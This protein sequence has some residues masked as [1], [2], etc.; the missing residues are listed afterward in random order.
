MPPFRPAHALLVLAI[1]GCARAGAATPRTPRPDFLRGACTVYE[2]MR[3]PDG[4]Y[5]D[6]HRLDGSRSRRSSIASFGPGLIALCVEDAL[7]WNPRAEQDALLTLYLLNGRGG[8]RIERSG[9]GYFSHFFDAG[10]GVRRGNFSTID[11]AIAAA[12]AVFCANHFTNAALRAEAAELWNSVAWTDA[13]VDGPGARVHRTMAASGAPEREVSRPFNEYLLVAWYAHAQRGGAASNFF[14]FYPP[15]DRC[16]H[17]A[18][19]G[20]PTDQPARSLSTFTILFPYYLA[21]PCHTDGTY[22]NQMTRWA[23]TERAHWAPLD[24]VAWGAGAGEG[25]HG[26]QVDRLGAHPDDIISP[27]VIAGFLP[28]DPEADVAIGRL[29]EDGR[30]W[31]Q[32]DGESVQWRFSLQQADWTPR[33]ING[34]D[35]STY[36]FGL[37]ATDPRLPAGFFHRGL[38]LDAVLRR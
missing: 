27:P 18:D 12:G 23:Q 36:L 34:V 35:F 24:P 19:F 13:L 14:G 8:Y 25:L 9:N 16:P 4:C 7:G 33:A 5:L 1:A 32:V 2:K 6:M 22:L 38:R 11:T 26:Y 30:G 20:L 31:L 28:V 37:A 3:E 10:T 15:L 21:E 17:S 29:W